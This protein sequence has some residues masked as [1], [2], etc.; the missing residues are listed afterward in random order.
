MGQAITAALIKELRERTNVG[1]A[2]CKQALVEADG[3]IDLAVQNLRKA[4]LAS[5]SKKAGREAKEGAIV[6]GENDSCVAL[7]EVNAETDFVV[8]NNLFQEFSQNIAK[9]IAATRPS[10]VDSFMQQQ[11]SADASVTMDEYRAT[12]IQSIGE[13]IQVARF[14]CFNK[15]NEQS[16]GVYSHQGGK[17][18]ALVELT[19]SADQQ[20]LAR[21]LA[22]HVAASRPEFL[23]QDTVPE[24][25]VA[26]ERDI[27]LAQ[28]EEQPKLKDKPDQVKQNIVDGKLRAF[29]DE[30]CLLRQKYV[31]DEKATVEEFLATQSKETGKDLK[32]SRFVLWTVGEAAS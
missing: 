16:I 11:Y 29:M 27:A 28:V 7:V 25:I 3:D 18:V 24:D 8:R 2:K 15:E 23:N 12:M 20:T 19:G 10:D 9:E 5:A 26:R 1:M 4:G 17:I 32:I 21:E 13:N 30:N 22:M 14:A 31:K 6:A